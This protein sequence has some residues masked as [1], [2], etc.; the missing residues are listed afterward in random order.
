MQD[1]IEGIAGLAI[2]FSFYIVILALI[3][4][5]AGYRWGYAFLSPIPFVS[6]IIVLMLAFCEW[7]IEA[8]LKKL[9]LLIAPKD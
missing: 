3:L 8:R 1:T 7:P 4:R 6:L 2:L 5:R 9:Q